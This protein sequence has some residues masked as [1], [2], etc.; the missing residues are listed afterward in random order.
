MG[1]KIFYKS[2]RIIKC[3]ILVVTSLDIQGKTTELLV[4]LIWGRHVIT[5]TK[6]F[7]WLP[8]SIQPIR[9]TGLF[10]FFR[11]ISIIELVLKHNSCQKIIWYLHKE[12]KKVRIFLPMFRLSWSRSSGFLGPPH[13]HSMNSVP[14]EPLFFIAIPLLSSHFHRRWVCTKNKL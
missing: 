7:R 6:L 8:K 12:G 14:V 2:H 10:F 1:S 13:F 11:E 9:F 3:Y 5:S 4:A